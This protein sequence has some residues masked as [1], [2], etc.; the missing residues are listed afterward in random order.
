MLKAITMGMH[1]PLLDQDTL[2]LQL[3]LTQQFMELLVI[4]GLIKKQKNQFTV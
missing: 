3:A 1:K 2:L 4:V